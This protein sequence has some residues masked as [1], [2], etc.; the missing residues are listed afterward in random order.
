MLLNTTGPSIHPLA[1]WVSSLQQLPAG[2]LATDHCPLSLTAQTIF[3]PHSSQIRP[4]QLPNENTV[5]GG[6]KSLTKVKVYYL[7]G[8]S[9]ICRASHFVTE[10]IR[11]F[12]HDLPLK[13]CRE[14]SQCLNAA[15]LTVLILT[16]ANSQSQ[17]C[18]AVE[19]QT[20]VEMTQPTPAALQDITDFY[21]F[22]Q[23]AISRD[24]NR[25]C[26]II[27]AN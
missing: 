1:C 26:K 27:L 12:K 7:H 10:A 19:P 25:L 6:V 23:I 21:S 8:S 24:G 18:K 14:C 11:L 16:P 3:Y 4:P 13:A 20:D 9:L 2:H 17:S 5:G 15:G 22:F